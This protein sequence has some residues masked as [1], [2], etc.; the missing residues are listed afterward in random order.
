MNDFRQK[1]EEAV[2][3]LG[4][5]LRMSH[6]Q[7]ARLARVTAALTSAYEEGRRSV[8]LGDFL[9]DPCGEKYRVPAWHL[10]EQYGDYVPCTLRRG[11]EGLHEHSDSGMTW[12]TRAADLD[13]T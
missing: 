3:P 6:E 8:G 13:P 7:I 2:H 1:A 10:V 12:T 11:H 5:P 4:L 9:A